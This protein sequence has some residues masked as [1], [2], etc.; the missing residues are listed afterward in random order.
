M[1]STFHGP[2]GAASALAAMETAADR[3]ASV[4]AGRLALTRAEA[5]AAV[6]AA[7]RA[8]RAVVRLR[9]VLTLLV[10]TASLRDQVRT[11]LDD[12]L[13]EC[14]ELDSELSTL[15]AEQRSLEDHRGAIEQDR[16][17]A[18]AL[19]RDVEELRRIQRAAGDLD[20]LRR[21]RDE[22]TTLVGTAA[23]EVD[24]VDDDIANRA[25]AVLTAADRVLGSMSARAAGGLAQVDERAAEVARARAALDARRAEADRL[26]DELETLAAENDRVLARVDE[27]RARVAG[28]QRRVDQAGGMAKAQA[29]APEH[30]DLAERAGRLAVELCDLEKRLDLLAE[31]VGTLRGEAQRRFEARKPVHLGDGRSMGGE[32]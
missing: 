21:V 31:G 14:E 16:A 29:E 9:P 30:P 10:N 5:I 20:A 8:M 11:A 23:D 1:P 27:L 28:M 12:A 3:A 4:L 2:G 26:A 24:Q 17:K 13:R 32:R 25:Q 18:E 22:L 19:R 15:A 7:D 6:A